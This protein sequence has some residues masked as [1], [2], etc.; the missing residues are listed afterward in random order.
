MMLFETLSVIH[1][2][3]PTFGFSSDG[4]NHLLPPKN[5]CQCTLHHLRADSFL[6]WNF[7]V[8][9]FMLSFPALWRIVYFWPRSATLRMELIC[10]LLVG[11]LPYFLCLWNRWYGLNCCTKPKTELLHGQRKKLKFTL[12]QIRGEMF[13]ATL[14]T[15]LSIFISIPGP[16]WQ[17][18]WVQDYPIT[19]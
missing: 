4:G 18:S 12:L 6:H 15:F 19:S 1:V 16:C 10:Q 3:R 8:Y 14:P 13:V 5:L 2:A 17:L 11:W 9:V 7:C